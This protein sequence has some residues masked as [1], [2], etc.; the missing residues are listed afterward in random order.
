MNGDMPCMV[1]AWEPTPA[2]VA[3]IAAGAKVLLRIVGQGHP[4]VAVYVGDP[5]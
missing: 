3:A 4:P 1:S 2:E 5:A